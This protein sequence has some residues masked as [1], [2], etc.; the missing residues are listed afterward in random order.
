MTA[1]LDEC[2]AASAWHRANPQPRLRRPEDAPGYIA[3]EDRPEYRAAHA[4][5]DRYSKK[6]HRMSRRRKKET[7]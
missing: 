7:P 2:R 3:P 1:P 5:W 6:S 4:M